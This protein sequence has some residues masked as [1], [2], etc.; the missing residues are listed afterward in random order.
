M[1]KFHT[2]LV[3]DIDGLEPEWT[4]TQEMECMDHQKPQRMAQSAADAIS[5]NVDGLEVKEIQVSE[6]V[7]K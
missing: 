3:V 5:E 6:T 4:M 7:Y 2:T 1:R